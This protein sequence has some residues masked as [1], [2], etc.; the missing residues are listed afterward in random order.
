MLRTHF[1]YLIDVVLSINCIIAGGL[2]LEKCTRIIFMSALYSTFSCFCVSKG[3]MVKKKETPWRQDD[4]IKKV[5][6]L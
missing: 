3:L 5:S 6:C 2:G 4:P 1:E